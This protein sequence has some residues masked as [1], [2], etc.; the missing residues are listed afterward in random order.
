[1]P[2]PLDTRTATRLPHAFG[3]YWLVVLHWRDIDGRQE[4][5]GIEVWSEPPQ[6]G[7]GVER[8]FSTRQK[9]RRRPITGRVLRALQL[10]SQIERDRQLTIAGLQ[11]QAEAEQKAAVNELI[12]S[13]SARSRKQDRAR[14]KLDRAHFEQVAAVYTA[15]Y[16]KNR[17]PTKAV[18]ATFRVSYPTAARWVS[19]CRGEPYNLLAPTKP[20]QASAEPMEKP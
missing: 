6:D 9:M 11:H 4:V 20:G 18:Q 5:V 15:A 8:L 3:G 16:S 2:L 1:M 14:Y 17:A 12:K 7:R 10:P 13:F 19:A